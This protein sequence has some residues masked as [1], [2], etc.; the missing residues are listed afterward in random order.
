M[1][2]ADSFTV[3]LGILFRVQVAALARAIKEWLASS[4]AQDVI[5][6]RD[7]FT[8][9]EESLARELDFSEFRKALSMLEDEQV[10]MIGGEHR[11]RIFKR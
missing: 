1:D 10:I 9:L 7:A 4:V 11:S 5:S 6:F 8:A 2:M 3:L